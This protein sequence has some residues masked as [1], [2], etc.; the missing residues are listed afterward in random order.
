MALWRV[1]F[2][3][4]MRLPQSHKACK[5]FGLG[6][7]IFVDFNQILTVDLNLG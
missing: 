4:Y 1:V 3:C 7:K 6:V 5:R 2:L